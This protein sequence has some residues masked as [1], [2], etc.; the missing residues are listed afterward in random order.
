LLALHSNP[1]KK[2]KCLGVI[3]DATK[4]YR[5]SRSYDFVTKIKIIDPDLNS[6]TVLDHDKKYLHVFIYSKDRKEAPKVMQIGDIIYLR[7]Y[8][9][10]KK[11]S[12]RRED[13]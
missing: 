1:E 11:K 6:T 8:D 7:L 13:I 4:P 2:V 3:L 9:V 12:E 5:T 10:I